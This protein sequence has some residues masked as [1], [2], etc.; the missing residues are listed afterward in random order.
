MNPKL[1][2]AQRHGFALTPPPAPLTAE[3][4]AIMQGIRERWGCPLNYQYQAQDRKDAHD[5]LS[6]ALEGLQP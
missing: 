1:T 5:A 6:H 2:R 3:D 4:A